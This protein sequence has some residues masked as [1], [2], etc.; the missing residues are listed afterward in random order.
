MN[1]LF[2]ST[3]I[4]TIFLDKDL[5][6]RSFTKEATNI[7]KMIESDAGRPLSDIVSNL[8]YDKFMDDIQQVV[9]RVTYKEMELETEDGKWFKT[10]IMPY[11][12]SNN[13]IDG[14]VITFN[15]ISPA[16]KQYMD[17][18]DAVN[19]AEGVIQTVREP[20]LVMDSDMRVISANPSFYKTFKLTPE[21][22]IKK[23]LYNLGNNE[24]DITALR[25]LLED[26]L[27]N[28][29]DLQDYVV[30]TDFPNIGH[31]KM[32]LNARQIYQEGKGTNMILLAMD[33]VAGQNE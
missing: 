10:R 24:W 12:T 31:M 22:T 7:I 11:K 4:A 29:I 6:I 28:E 27:P 3:E 20:L 30:E 26:L 8:K 21:A 2:N 15:N 33:E 32:V 9:E 16:K 23:V 13:V 14:A 25:N 5:N 1:N 18:L 19:F 17:A